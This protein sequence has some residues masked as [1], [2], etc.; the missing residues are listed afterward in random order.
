MWPAYI[1]VGLSVR[2]ES[3][4]Y[5]SIDGPTDKSAEVIL[6]PKK[7]HTSNKLWT[8]AVAAV[9]RGSTSRRRP[10]FRQACLN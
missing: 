9:L 1:Y 2:S 8:E 7:L 6:G 10:G 3:I 4:A 5:G